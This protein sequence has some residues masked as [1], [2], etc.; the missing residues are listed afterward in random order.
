V[1]ELDHGRGIA[2]Q[3]GRAE[4][5]AQNPQRDHVLASDGGEVVEKFKRHHPSL[6]LMDVS[7]PVQNGLDATRAIREYEAAQGMPHTPII[8]VTAHALD[9]DAQRCF[10]AGMDDYLPKPVSP[11]ALEAKIDGWLG[12]RSRPLAR[13]SG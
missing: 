1:F 13:G 11:T 8:G 6:I 12:E 2:G 10:D 5:V 7:M 4:L 9:G 3:L